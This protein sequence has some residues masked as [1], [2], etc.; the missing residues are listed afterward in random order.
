MNDGIEVQA[1]KNPALEEAENV[2]DNLSTWLNDTLPSDGSFCM[3]DP[4]NERRIIYF[5][6]NGDEA[7]FF[8]L[9]V[10]PA[11]VAIA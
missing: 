1:M 6:P 10:H 7:V 9:D 2:A 5:N 8:V 4:H 3:V 11:R